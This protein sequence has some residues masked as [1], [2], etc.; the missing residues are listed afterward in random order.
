MNIWLKALQSITD[1]R[2]LNGFRSPV[3]Q[4][5]SLLL[6]TALN[7]FVIVDCFSEVSSVNVYSR[8]VSGLRVTLC[9]LSQFNTAFILNINTNYNNN[10]E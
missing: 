4:V 1:Q 2:T 6:I 7:Q 8:Q 9:P 5:Y 10:M 3:L